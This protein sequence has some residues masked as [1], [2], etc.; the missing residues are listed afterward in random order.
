MISRLV[1]QQGIFFNQ[2]KFV[3]LFDNDGYC[4]FRFSDHVMLI[5]D[6]VFERRIG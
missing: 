1:E 4:D 2:K 5:S 3:V 6:C